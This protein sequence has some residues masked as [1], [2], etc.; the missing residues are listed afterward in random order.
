MS[1]LSLHITFEQ[2]RRGAE[3][4]LAD[5]L[6][7][8]YGIVQQILVGTG[9]GLCVE[10]VVQKKKEGRR[11]EPDSDQKRVRRIKS[12][13]PGVSEPEREEEGKGRERERRA[14]M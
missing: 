1:P 4:D 3:L 6:K 8:E 11:I 5:C 9:D 14:R 13:K 7:M 2:L 10:S 12:Q